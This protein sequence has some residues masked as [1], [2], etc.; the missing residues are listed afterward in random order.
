MQH[1]EN[2][3]GCQE[4]KICID[5]LP[6]HEPQSFQ[7]RLEV[8]E[9]PRLLEMVQEPPGV[10]DYEFTLKREA[11]RILIDGQFKGQLILTC[12]RCLGNLEFQSDENF[13]IRLQPEQDLARVADETLLTLKELEWDVY[14]QPTLNLAEL[15]EEQV[16]VSMP[17]KNICDV[18]CRGLCPGCGVNLNLQNCLCTKETDDHP[19]AVLKGNGSQIDNFQK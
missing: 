7:G 18:E 19:F 16:L 11:Q 17:A 9:C 3:Q 6:D 12:D 15:I 2:E 10:V 4:L 5:D 14:D 1:L 13:C 8:D